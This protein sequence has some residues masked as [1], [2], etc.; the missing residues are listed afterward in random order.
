MISQRVGD[1]DNNIK[2]KNSE[3][4]ES[5]KASEIRKGCHM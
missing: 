4:S 3:I 5:I 1:S 2:E